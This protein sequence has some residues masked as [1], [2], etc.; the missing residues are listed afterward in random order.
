V[1]HH[2]RPERDPNSVTPAVDDLLHA[3]KQVAVTSEVVSL[4]AASAAVK[5][6]GALG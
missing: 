4:L 5:Q 1:D 6:P 3:A 2:R